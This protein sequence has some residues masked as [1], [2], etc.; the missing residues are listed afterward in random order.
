MS[1]SASFVI[2]P[3]K[4]PSPSASPTMSNMS[5]RAF[6][7]LSF[8]SSKMSSMLRPPRPSPSPSP[9]P[10]P[11]PPVIIPVPASPVP[12]PAPSGSKP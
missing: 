6:S 8:R 12:V 9:V 3:A 7:V 11:S 10:S 5:S 4:G 1:F 2:D